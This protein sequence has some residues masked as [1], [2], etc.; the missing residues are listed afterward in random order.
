MLEDK[1]ITFRVR[2][3]LYGLNV[4][5]V[6]EITSLGEITPVDLAPP[7][8]KGLINLRGQVA[9]VVDLAVRLGQEAVEMG[10]ETR[11]IILKPFDQ[12]RRIMGKGHPA[13]EETRELLGLL[14]DQVE[15]IIT[16]TEDQYHAVPAHFDAVDRNLLESTL[17]QDETL[18]F[19]L[20]LEEV[21]T[22]VEAG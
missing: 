18:I 12:I 15:D 19:M 2:D 6:Q 11:C 21:A 1:L 16:A 22:L 14:V 9:T 3:S 8:L 20:K 4:L 13:L 10:T 5:C 7:S 17:R